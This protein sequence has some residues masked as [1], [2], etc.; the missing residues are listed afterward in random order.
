MDKQYP[1]KI[2]MYGF[3]RPA[4]HDDVQWNRHRAP[5]NPQWRPFH[6]PRAPFRPRNQGF[7]D[8][9]P[10]NPAMPGGSEEYWCE[11]CDRGFPTEDL[12]NKHKQ[13]HQKCNIDGCQFI[14]HPKVITKHIQ[15]QHS[16]GL[17]KK[18]NKLN[19]PEE[20][21]KWREERRKRYP[22]KTNIDKKAAELKEKIDRGE[23]MGIGR[24]EKPNRKQTP[25]RSKVL[26]TPE[27]NRS[28]VPFTGIQ[29]LAM[30]SDEGDEDEN[31]S[32]NDLIED[33]DI[34]TIDDAIKGEENLT[35]KPAVCG[36][37]SSLMCEYGSSDEEIEDIGN[38]KDAKPKESSKEDRGS[39]NHLVVQ[40]AKLLQPN[41]SCVDVDKSLSLDVK[42][43]TEFSIKSKDVENHQTK[44]IS[45][46]ELGTK[47][48]D[49]SLKPGHKL[50]LD[51]KSLYNNE[52]ESDSRPEEIKM[53]T[54]E[55]L[56][57]KS[58]KNEPSIKQD[59]PELDAK[60]DGND[61]DSAPEEVK[62][63]KNGETAKTNEQENDNH[64]KNKIVKKKVEVMRRKP[65][66]RKPKAKLPS[67]LIY[68]LLAKEMKQERNKVLH[69]FSSKDI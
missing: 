2:T 9:R 14:A 63:V 54:H 53:S 28:L 34:G 12:L 25:R 48:N 49:T 57:T 61:D 30:D 35:E 36:A 52:D 10:P 55:H 13:Q 29:C 50:H 68:R 59:K 5:H 3:P 1:N 19:N 26:P 16:T 37:L 23:K 7:Y 58:I 46:S 11:T 33:D 47:S 60:N 43:T 38:N 42:N 56:I 24:R 39:N 22:T 6:G 31:L 40:N 62:V 17:F 44:E 64:S 51:S 18:I 67:T 32:S 8:H 69:I 4:I 66:Y 65:V 21:D 15:M 45:A 27:D 41:K 20:I